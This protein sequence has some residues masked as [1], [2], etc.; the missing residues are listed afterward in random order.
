MI[1]VYIY[2]LV[3]DYRQEFRKFQWLAFL[4]IEDE[5]T[6]IREHFF[7]AKEAGSYLRLIGLFM[8]FIRINRIFYWYGCFGV[9]GQVLYE[10]FNTIPLHWFL[11]STVPNVAVYLFM[12]LNAFEIYNYFVLIFFA[13]AMFTRNSLRSL[14]ERRKTLLLGNPKKSKLRQLAKQNLLQFNY[15]IKN[16]RESQ[17]NFNYTF[18]YRSVCGHSYRVGLS[19]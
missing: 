13:N 8:K 6:L 3:S 19:K 9:M 11:F 1:R 7:T 10:A 17:R 5:Q 15:I 14:A 18:C 4:R 12:T 16:F 2:L